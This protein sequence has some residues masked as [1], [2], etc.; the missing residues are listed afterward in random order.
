MKRAGRD[1]CGGKEG[2]AS[3]VVMMGGLDVI[4]V[5]NVG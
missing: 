1:G 4:G 5:D 2:E 3:G